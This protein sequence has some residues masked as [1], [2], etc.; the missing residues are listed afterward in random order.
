MT[1][2]ATGQVLLAGNP[3]AG[4]A[5]SFAALH[6]VSSAC[7]GS[8]DYA[9]PDSHSRLTRLP[10]C[11]PPTRQGVGILIW[12]FSK[13]NHPAHRC[14][15]PTLRNTPRDVSRKTRGQDGVAFS[16]PVGLLHPLQH[17]G[18][19]ENTYRLIVSGGVDSELSLMSTEKPRRLRHRK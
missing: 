12:R 6:V 14:L 11:L 2:V 13:L 10:C 7:A 4:L 8:N 15:R 17:A 3:P 5:A 16:F 19:S 9:G 18:C 1:T